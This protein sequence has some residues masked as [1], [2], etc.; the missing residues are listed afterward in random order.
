MPSLDTI[1]LCPFCRGPKRKPNDCFNQWHFDPLPTGDEMENLL[2]GA[3][4]AS[5]AQGSRPGPDTV[6]DALA[7]RGEMEDAL[8][9]L[10]NEMT[11]LDRRRECA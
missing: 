3:C 6:K 8:R 10:L 2:L 11:S 5:R 9:D 7:A 1:A 4:L